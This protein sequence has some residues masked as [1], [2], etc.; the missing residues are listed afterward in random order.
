MDEK[1]EVLKIDNGAEGTKTV[2][3]KFPSNAHSSKEEKQEKRVEKI[4]KGRV[5]QRKK[6]FMKK[7]TDTFI[8]ED[9]DNVL[10]YVVQDILIPAAK[11]TIYD[12]FQGSLEMFLF[13]GEKRGSRT[14]REQSKSFVSYNNYSSTNQNRRP[15]MSPRSR[16]RH[17]FDDLVFSSR[18]EAQEV[19]S[20]MVDL[21]IDYEQATVADLYGYVGIASSFTD[22]KYGWTDL[23]SASVSRARDGY[24]LNLPK[25]ILLD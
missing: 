22:N 1:K 14:R 12:M 13:P 23:S 4:V 5:L 6:S 25:T 15:D 24:L 2:N 20:N 7:L 3:V 16:A 19:L 11:S 17:D 9:V 21:I 18:G 10:S 8:G